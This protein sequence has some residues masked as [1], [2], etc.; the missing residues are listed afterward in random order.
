MWHFGSQGYVMTDGN[1]GG[2]IW[3]LPESDLPLANILN[4]P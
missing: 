3:F 2:A 1:A 4:S